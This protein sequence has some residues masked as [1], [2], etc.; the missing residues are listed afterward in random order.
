MAIRPVKISKTLMYWV[1][2]QKKHAD[3]AGSSGGGG[4]IQTDNLQAES[5]ETL[6]DEIGNE[7]AIEVFSNKLLT[8]SSEVIFDELSD[9]L[10][11]Q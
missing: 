8:E 1:A 7:I 10:L 11:T 6:F 3:I 5:G 9:A 4:G 2:L